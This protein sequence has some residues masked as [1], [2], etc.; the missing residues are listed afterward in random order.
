MKAIYITFLVIIILVACVSNTEALTNVDDSTS[1]LKQ[2]HNLMLK[3][4]AKMQ[5][6]EQSLYNSIK[7]NPKETS[8]IISSIKK[9][10]QYRNKLFDKLLS[11][12]DT[13]I[14]ITPEMEQN[15]ILFGE[16]ND[17]LGKMEQHLSINKNKKYEKMKM[18]EI[19]NYYSERSKAYVSFFKFLF[20]CSIPLLVIS[21]LMKQNIVPSKYGNVLIGIVL[22][23]TIFWGGLRYYDIISRDNMNFNEYDFDSEFDT[24][25][26]APS[27]FS[28][29]SLM[30]T[31]CIDE[32]CCAKGTTYDNAK[33][34]CVITGTK[35]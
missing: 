6:V 32:S 10:E 27:G 13:A 14:K 19:N 28:G 24:E 23:V 11:E 26:S 34:V 35:N 16:I 25:G 31:G 9:M 17:E 4:I 7:T 22:F 3:N 8:N 12:S 2:E 15:N 1:A 30:P 20:Y 33:G 5:T 29:D 21:I 18:A